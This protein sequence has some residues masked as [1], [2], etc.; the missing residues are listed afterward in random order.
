MHPLKHEAAIVPYFEGSYYS[1]KTGIS[2]N[3]E[4]WRGPLEELF[5]MADARMPAR[6]LHEDDCDGRMWQGL[7]AGVR[8]W[9]DEGCPAWRGRHKG[10]VQSGRTGTTA[11]QCSHGGWWSDTPNV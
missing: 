10:K 8:V 3:R 6:R 2:C 1:K 7:W 9:R 11:R 5:S 4:V